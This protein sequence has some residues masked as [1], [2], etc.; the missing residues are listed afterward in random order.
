MNILHM[1]YAVEVAKLGSLSKAAESLLI[2]QPN[3]SRS[4]KDLESDLGITI[5]NRT[6]KGMTLTPEG[7]VFIGHAQSILNRIDEVET[8]YKHPSAP[9][10][11]FSVS[12]VKTGYVFSAVS[13]FLKSVSDEPIEITFK[14]T[15][16][17]KTITNVL[18]ND[19]RF[20]IIRCY[21]DNEVFIKSMLN[22]K[23]LAFE[24]LAE[25]EF[26]VV[27]NNANPLSK[28]DVVSYSD[29]C[30]LIEITDTEY[31]SVSKNAKEMPFDANCR[32]V[33]SEG[34]DKLELLSENDASFAFCAPEPNRVLEKYGLSQLACSEQK[35]TCIDLLIYQKD[36]KFSKLDKSFLTL[37]KESKTEYFN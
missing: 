34:V 33:L 21:D 30:G 4:I 28:R 12:S 7:E 27:L 1:K 37:L 24:T 22:E 29:L 16:S 25:L 10:R 13:R 3:I 9:K 17:Q 5:F 18:S 32:V 19:S 20:G 6:A 11:K 2:A 35:K 26:V 36:M 15:N 14:E 23:G 31:S 8:L